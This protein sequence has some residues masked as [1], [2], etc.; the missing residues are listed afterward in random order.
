MRGRETLK[1]LCP[2]K[3]G[4]L[5]N[6]QLVWIHWVHTHTHTEKRRKVSWGSFNI[7]NYRVGEI[8]FQRHET[9]CIR[10]MIM[11]FLLLGPCSSQHNVTQGPYS[12]WSQFTKSTFLMANSCRYVFFQQVNGSLSFTTH[13]PRATLSASANSK[14]TWHLKV[15]FA[16]SLWVSTSVTLKACT[17]AW[18]STDMANN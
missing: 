9:Y 4:K 12:S 5:S 1:A 7:Y 8:V 3:D 2:R 13:L 17:S 10:A 15:L 6:H 18:F 11:M 14:L 16:L